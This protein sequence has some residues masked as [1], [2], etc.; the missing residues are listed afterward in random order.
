VTLGTDGE[1]FLPNLAPG[2]YSVLAFDRTDIEYTNPD[3]LGRFM[4]QASH[5]DLHANDEHTVN[6]ALIHGNE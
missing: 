4:A 2:S 1:F 6:L 5:V 3:V